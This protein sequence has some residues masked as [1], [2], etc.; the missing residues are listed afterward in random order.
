MVFDHVMRSCRNIA[1]S[2]KHGYFHQYSDS[3]GGVG[4]GREYYP[5]VWQRW[6]RVK[7]RGF[8]RNV[9]KSLLTTTYRNSTKMISTEKIDSTAIVLLKQMLKFVGKCL[10]VK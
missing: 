10:T 4:D 9:K 3:F 2:Y 6:W 8:R 5:I 7:F 1:I